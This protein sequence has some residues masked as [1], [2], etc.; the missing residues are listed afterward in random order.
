MSSLIVPSRTNLILGCGYLGRRVAQLWMA[1]GQPVAAL[2]RRN[3]DQLAALGIV[4]VRGDVLE[5][6]SLRGLPEAETVLYAVGL[7]RTSGRSMHE[8]YIQG[9]GNVLDRLKS[10]R[11]FIYVSSTSVYGQS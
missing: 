11:R 7:D 10:C 8:V 6:E 4:P 9:L 3:G 5:P 2:T 1:G